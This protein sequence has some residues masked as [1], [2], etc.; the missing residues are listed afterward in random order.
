MKTQSGN[1]VITKDMADAIFAAINSGKMVEVNYV[2]DDDSLSATID[3]ELMRNSR[4][5]VKN[6]VG[7]KDFWIVAVFEACV[8]S[9]QAKKCCHPFSCFVRARS[10]NFEIVEIHEKCPVVIEIS[11]PKVSKWYDFILRFFNLFVK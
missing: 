9:S 5:F 11:N 4:A 1:Q 8:D 7:S 3:Q 10:E 6:I 2:G